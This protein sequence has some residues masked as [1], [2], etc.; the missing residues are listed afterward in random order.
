MATEKGHEGQSLDALRAQCTTLQAALCL[1]E[2]RLDALLTLNQM[3]DASFQDVTDFALDQAVRLTRSQLGYL[4]FVNEDESVL[5][6]H[7]WSKTAMSQCKIVDKPIVYPVHQTGLWGEAI[8]QRRPVITNDYQAPNPLK[9]GCPEGHVSILRHMNVPVFSGRRIVAVAGV[10]NKQEPYDESDVRQ[11]TLLIEGMWKIIERRRFEAELLTYR[12]HLEELVEQRNSQLVAANE[13]FE[14]TN[15]QLQEQIRHREAADEEV[16]RQR[17]EIRKYLDIA[18]TIFLVLD[19]QGHVTLLN[20]KGH[21][22][23]GYPE[24]SLV[25]KNW[26]TTCVPEHAR[27]QRWTIFMQLLQGNISDYERVENQVLTSRGAMRTVGWHH[28]ILQDDAG[29]IVGTLSSGADITE[30]RKMEAELSQAHKLEAVGR[31]A[32]GIAHEINTPIQYISDNMRF[33]SDCWQS[34]HEL[35]GVWSQILETAENGVVP[36]EMLDRAKSLAEAMDL[37]YVAEEIPRAI[38]QSLEGA[39]RV[40]QVVAAMKEFAHPGSQQMVATDLNRAVENTLTISHNEWKYVADLVADFD[41]SLPPVKCLPGEVKQ[42]VLNLLVNAA[43]AIGE[44]ARGK[45]TITV[46]TRLDGAWAEIRIQDTGAGIPKE[47]RDRVFEP[48]FTTKQVGKGTGQGLAIA[49]SIVVE[50]HG[51]TIT[52]ESE[53][54]RGT[55]FLVRLPVDGRAGSGDGNGA[56]VGKDRVVPVLP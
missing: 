22:I 27:E 49:R 14:Q 26:F 51:G 10:G 4:A 17:D 37:G 33:L 46:S 9:K 3:V 53:I 1:N 50:K 56:P 6:M 2:F 18:G 32:A 13:E 20:R 44:A 23:L 8:R 24:G 15:G 21:D 48:F 31:L 41:P 12:D 36:R 30:L 29:M 5:T 54:G 35:G 40:A 52:F 28:S 45:G 43:H 34:I 39:D 7:S 19:R 47:V 11:L 16:C 38:G 55:T 25:G 42:V